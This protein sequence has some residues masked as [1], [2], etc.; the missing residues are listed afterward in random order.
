M[1]RGH[2]CPGP[3]QLSGRS[4]LSAPTDVIPSDRHG[5]GAGVGRATQQGLH[6]T[7]FPCVSPLD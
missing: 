6:Q 7:H 5:P 4:Q 3:R 1:G 2:R